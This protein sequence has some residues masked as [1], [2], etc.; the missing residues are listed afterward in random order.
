MDYDVTVHVTPN[1]DDGCGHG[2][3]EQGWERDVCYCARD[4]DR[5]ADHGARPRPNLTRGQGYVGS[6]RPCSPTQ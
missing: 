4:A 3:G 2:V 1:T 6:R 5:R